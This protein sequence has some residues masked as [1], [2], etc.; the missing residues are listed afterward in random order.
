MAG[1]RRVRPNPTAYYVDANATHK[2]QTKF[3]TPSLPQNS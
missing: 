1:T 2:F 3:S